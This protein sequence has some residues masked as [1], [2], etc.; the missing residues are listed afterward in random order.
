VR[1]LL[2]H[3]VD[4]DKRAPG[5]VIGMI[6][7]DPPERW[8]LGYGRLSATDEHV[9]DGDTVFEIGSITKVFTG[10]LLAQA[11]LKGEVRLDDPISRYLPEGITAP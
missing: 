7:A 10:T 1:A 5:M 8:V 11:V 9:P 6:A 3:L 4:E 2:V